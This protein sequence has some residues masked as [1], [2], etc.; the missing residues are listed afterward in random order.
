MPYSIG[1]IFIHHTFLDESYAT[2]CSVFPDVSPDFLKEKAQQIGNDPD[3]LQAFIAKSLEEKSNFPSKKEYDRQQIKKS[4]EQ[5]VRRMT[6][7]DFV[8][9][10]EV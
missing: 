5:K 6:P 9:Q 3:Q 8:D 2:L 10:Y 4:E 1:Y 7:R